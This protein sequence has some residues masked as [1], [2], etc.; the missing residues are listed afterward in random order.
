MHIS[1]PKLCIIH[2]RPMVN[3]SHSTYQVTIN[4]LYRAMQSYCMDLVD[5]S[6]S[7]R[8]VQIRL[9]L[10]RPPDSEGFDLSTTQMEP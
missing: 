5:I 6:R 3:M 8:H 10:V 4:V 7:Q 2:L 1:R 9:Q